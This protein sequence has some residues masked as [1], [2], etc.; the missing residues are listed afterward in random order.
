MRE[1]PVKLTTFLL[2]AAGQVQDILTQPDG[3][4]A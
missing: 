1:H 4:S 2:A 3:E